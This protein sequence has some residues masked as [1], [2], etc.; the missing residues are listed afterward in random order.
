MMMIMLWAVVLLLLSL[1]TAV[2][3]VAGRAPDCVPLSTSAASRPMADGERV[4][5]STQSGCKNMCYRN[6][7]IYIYICLASSKDLQ[8]Q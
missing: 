1:M 4:L 5:L 8:L 7:Y 6:I 2:S 3:Q